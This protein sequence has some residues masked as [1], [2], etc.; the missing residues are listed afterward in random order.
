M[1][2]LGSKK[3]LIIKVNA[4]NGL[5]KSFTLLLKWIKKEY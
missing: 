1:D 4:F 3:P 2:Q 5:T